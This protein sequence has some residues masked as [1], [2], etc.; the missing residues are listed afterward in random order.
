[1]KIHYNANKK[2]EKSCLSSSYN[3]NVLKLRIT[4]LDIISRKKI[5]QPNIRK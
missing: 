1:M 3:N 2:I 5:Q 4:S